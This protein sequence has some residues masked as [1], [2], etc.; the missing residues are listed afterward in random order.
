MRN[1]ISVL[2]GGQGVVAME[3]KKMHDLALNCSIEWN[4][5]AAASDGSSDRVRKLRQGKVVAD[6][7]DDDVV[8]VDVDPLWR[9]IRRDGKLLNATYA[10][11]SFL[12]SSSHYC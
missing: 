12:L 11:C 9:M 8:D 6:D 5:A 3:L 1:L 4:K 7:D 10:P 2:R